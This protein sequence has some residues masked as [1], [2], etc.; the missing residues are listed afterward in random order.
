MAPLKSSL[1]LG[2]WNNLSRRCAGPS[3][4]NREC[5]PLPGDELMCKLVSSVTSHSEIS[6]VQGGLIGLT[7]SY[8]SAGQR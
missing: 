4:C 6:I 7:S 3:F 2:V 1:L 5:T 8:V